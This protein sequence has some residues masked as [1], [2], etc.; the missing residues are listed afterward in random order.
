MRTFASLKYSSQSALFF[1]LFPIYNF[2]LIFNC[3]Y[4]VPLSVIWSSVL[5]TFLMVTCEKCAD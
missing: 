2:A 3:L 4:T 5:P 1:D